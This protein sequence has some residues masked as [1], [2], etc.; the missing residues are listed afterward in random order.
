[1][2]LNNHSPGVKLGE[3][4]SLFEHTSLV[5]FCESQMPPQNGAIERF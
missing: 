4:Q 1:M 3:Q 2:E 5:L